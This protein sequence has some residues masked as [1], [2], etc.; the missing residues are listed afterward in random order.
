MS[1]KGTS[2][3]ETAKKGADAKSGGSG[4]RGAR[5]RAGRHKDKCC[6]PSDV[7]ERFGLAFSAAAVSAL[8]RFSLMFGELFDYLY[9][10]VYWWL[11][12]MGTVAFLAGDLLKWVPLP[13]LDRNF[14]REKR[15]PVE[16]AIMIFVVFLA[17]F[18]AWRDEHAKLETLQEKYQTE[19]VALAKREYDHLSETQRQILFESLLTAQ[20]GQ[21][22]VT[23][24]SE[25]N[26]N[27]CEDLAEDLRDVAHAAK[28][29]A[30]GAP[31]MISDPEA[32]G[33]R[34]LTQDPAPLSATKF[35][36]ALSK[37]GIKY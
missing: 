36:L 29:A 22:H 26:C 7:H 23:V 10:S 9:A 8:K 32:G 15:R 27:E 5:S 30:N 21:F 2:A 18:Q 16:V 25:P 4:F 37:A 31:L 24:N 14:P 13:W 35:A 17:G 28:W 11:V 12:I 20:S 1:Q 6:W 3:S 33:L 34:I 19:R